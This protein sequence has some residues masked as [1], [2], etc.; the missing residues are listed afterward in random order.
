M[1]KVVFLYPQKNH[2]QKLEDFFEF[3]EKNGVLCYI[4]SIT[5]YETASSKF[6]HANRFT[7]GGWVSEKSV[8]PD[9]IFDKTTASIETELSRIRRH[10]SETFSFIN[11][12]ELNELCTNK[13]ET[14]KLFP[15]ISPKSVLVTS[16][17][18]IGKV[19][20]LPSTMV[21]SKPLRGFGGTEIRVLEKSTFQP[22]IDGPL[23]VQEFIETKKGIPGI[24]KKRHD[25]RILMLNAIPF[26][27]II[28][29][30]E[31]GSFLSNMAQGGKV[32]VVPI[33]SLP[34]KVIQIIETVSDTLSKFFPALY[35]IDIMLDETGTA[36]LTELN[37]RP[38]LSLASSEIPFREPYY[39]S[40]ITFLKNI[41]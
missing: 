3:A 20:T 37:S 17:S 10:I 4:A 18:D 23:L 28:R 7:K 38:A 39:K 26:H 13:W 9:I 14:Y 35:S 6:S 24:T 12:L 11:K 30:P 31:A 22:N 34:N 19:R 1:L 15:D 27:S 40:I 29:T 25:L 8:I 32:T 5:A 41:V 16:N 33:D 21:V 36:F 2:V